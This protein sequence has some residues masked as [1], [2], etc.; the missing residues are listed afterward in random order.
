MLR[1]EGSGF[2]WRDREECRVKCSDI[3]FQEMSAPGSYLESKDQLYINGGFGV[4]ALYR[5]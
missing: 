1:I 2:L 3:F 5:V 4:N